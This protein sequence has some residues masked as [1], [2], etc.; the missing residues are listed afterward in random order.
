MSNLNKLIEQLQKNNINF[1]TDV[2]LDKYTS[3][4]IG[5]NASLFVSPNSEDELIKTYV[6]CAKLEVKTLILGYGSNMLI[7]DEGFD[8]AVIY[9]NSNFSKV[10][11]I[12]ENIIRANAGASLARVCNFAKDNSLTGLEFAFGIPASIGGAIYMNA[13]AYGGEVK[14]VAISV[15]YADKDGAVHEKSVEELNF[16]Y[17]HTDFCDN[18]W[19]ILSADFKLN[20][21]EKD[22]IKALMDETY[23][24]RKTKQPLEYPSAGSTF[25]RP[26]NAFAA[27]LIDECGLK[28]KSVGGAMVSEKH[29]GFIINYDKATCKDVLDLI[30][31]VKQDVLNKTGIN[32]ECEVKLIG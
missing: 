29:S 26:P 30:E 19:I 7:C 22:E 23:L 8:G 21:G 15:R 10:D 25:K 1:K 6:L 20:L 11:F 3:F 16:S 4:K 14:D 27:Q 13:G 9:V 5:G 28:G 18:D 24:K 17:R 12:A 31:Y 2:K 32:L